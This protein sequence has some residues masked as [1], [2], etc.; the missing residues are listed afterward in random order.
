MKLFNTKWKRAILITVVVLLVLIIGCAIY[1]SD[2]YRADK[3]QIEAFLPNVTTKVYK[4]GYITVGDENSDVGFVFYPGGKVEYDAYL[5]LMRSISSQGVF[6]VLYEMPFN[7][8]V[9]DINAADGIHEEYPSVSSW[10][11]GG[12]SLGGS[13][14]ASYLSD[15]TDVFSGLVLL[16]AYSTADLSDAGTR[17][18][19]IYGSEDGV[20]NREKYEKNKENLPEDFA[21]IVIDGGSHAYF[22]M[23]GEQ[24]GDGKATISREHQIF[25]SADAIVDFLYE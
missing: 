15:N 14:A 5:P 10:Y 24:S 3:E 1:V 17:V 4:N 23:Y 7:L 20:M 11:I 8:A 25:F 12:H 16:G 9:L 22:G 18:L 13:M 19:S 6:C 21:E 2:Y